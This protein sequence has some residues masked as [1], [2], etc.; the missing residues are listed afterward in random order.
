LEETT[1]PELEYALSHVL[2]CTMLAPVCGRVSFRAL[3]GL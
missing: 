2:Y 3:C 1:G